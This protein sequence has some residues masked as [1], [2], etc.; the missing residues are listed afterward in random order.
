VNILLGVVLLGFLWT[1]WASG[2]YAGPE[3]PVGAWI[4]PVP[5][6][7]ILLGVLVVAIVRGR[8]AWLPGGVPAATLLVIGFLTTICTAL[9]GSFERHS[10]LF[11]AIPFLMVLA[12]FWLTGLLR[13]GILGPAVLVT[14][15]L[16]GYGIL[17]AAVVSHARDSMAAAEQQYQRERADA[18]ARS[19]QALR[20]YRA[21]PP[22]VPLIRL[23]DMS[24]LENETV[25]REVRARIANWPQRDQAIAAVLSDGTIEYP[26]LAC[27]LSY[28]AWVHPAPPASLAPA[29]AV[30]MDR[31]YPYW[32]SIVR[33]SS[34]PSKSEPE[35]S[36]VI[37]AA[38]RIR[39]AG[40]DLRPQ[41]AN[42]HQLLKKTHE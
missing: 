32:D 33:N 2:Q 22:D 14:A 16:A 30:A 15:S 11:Q 27:T 20:E 40:G 19:A 7:L 34:Y 38:E 3:G 9:L 12:C 37:A 42:W 8:F 1:F 4:V 26:Q 28:I 39:Q 31:S 29:F 21:L 17:G 24:F 18:E 5:F 41:L 25:Q 35:I 6:L 23:L 13:I 10:V 36:T